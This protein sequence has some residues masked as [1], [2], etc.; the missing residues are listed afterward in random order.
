[1]ARLL[2]LLHLDVALTKSLQAGFSVADVK[3]KASRVPTFAVP[4][5]WEYW[6]LDTKILGK[7]H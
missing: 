6:A 4:R 1:M 7:Q 5:H 3:C 2:S